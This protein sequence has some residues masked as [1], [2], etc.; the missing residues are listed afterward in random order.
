ML[1]A[2]WPQVLERVPGAELALVGDGPEAPHLAALAVD[3]VR[4]A[5]KSADVPAWLAAADVVALPSRWDVMALT[6]LEAMAR[7]RSVV[8]TDVDGAREALGEKA[9]AVVPV[10]DPAALADA[11]V[12]RLLDPG[13]AAAEGEAGR[14]AAIARHD[15]LRV[16][17]ATAELY[18][19]LA[20]V[21]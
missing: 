18:A 4:L 6:M 8:T 10:E 9:G 7:G 1:L 16:A 21:S 13:R 12:E 3:G 11:L 2:A 20:A 19:E 15:F 17:D 14:A 5:G